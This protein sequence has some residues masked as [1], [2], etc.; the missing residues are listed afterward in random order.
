M[1]V[2]RLRKPCSEN[3]LGTKKREASGEFVPAGCK[4][5]LSGGEN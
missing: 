5:E 2:R 3:R 1:Y 4:K